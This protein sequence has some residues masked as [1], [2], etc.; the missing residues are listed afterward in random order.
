MLSPPMSVLVCVLPARGHVSPTLAVV[1]ELV[2]AG[3]AVHVVTGQ[4]YRAPFRAVGATVTVLAH[5]ADFDDGDLDGSF[6]GRRGLTGLRLARHDLTEVFVRPMLSRWETLRKALD[7]WT[8][9]L[10]LLDPFFLAGI[11]LLLTRSG[12][13]PRVMVLGFLPIS[14]APITPP[15][16]G[17]WLRERVT[18]FGVH[19]ALGPVQREAAQLTQDLTGKRLDCWFTDWIGLSDGILQM[20]CP[21]FEYPRPDPPTPIHFIGLQT[22]SDR[23][24]HPLPSWWADLD[25]D[26]PIIHLTQGTVANADHSTV[27]KPALDALADRDCLVVVSTGGQDLTGPLPVNVRAAAYLPYDDLL[28][29]CSLMITNG[30]Y[31]GVN[32]ALR[33][34][35]PLLVVGATE[36]KRAVAQR[37]TWSKAGIGIGRATTSPSRIAR[38]VDQLLADPQYK[39][40]ALEL[41]TEM[42][43]CPTLTQ[44]LD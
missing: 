15:G 3:H 11:P 10:V 8:P 32:L 21:S 1:A 6:P 9:D 20:T 44:T 36:D 16:P 13:R 14:M 23:Q 19:Q 17:H 30:G 39:N 18:R 41:A 22:T 5:D 25:T 33:H 29:R 40:R 28:P 2:G 37:V 24:D 38:A 42:A 34:G 4:R 31:G 7:E 26:V 43:E 27:I 35:V 12:R